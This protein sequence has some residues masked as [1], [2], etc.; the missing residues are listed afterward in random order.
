MADD[1]Q[2]T[3]RTHRALSVSVNTLI[4]AEAR[5]ARLAK[6]LA[7]VERERHREHEARVQMEHELSAA[8][9][10]ADGKE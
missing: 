10:R 6:R 5:E 1:Q 3:S 8:L 2:Y 9:R 4:A 7:E